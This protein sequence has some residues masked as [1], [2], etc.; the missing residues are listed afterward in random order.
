MAFFEWHD[1]ISV[2]APLIDTDHSA[3]IAIIHEL[4]Y[5]LEVGQAVDRT[6]MANHVKELVKSTQ[7]HFSREESMLRAA[8]SAPAALPKGLK[9]VRRTPTFTEAT[10]PKAPTKDH[11]TKSDIWGV[12]DVKSGR[13]RYTIPSK[14][15]TIEIEAGDTAIIEPEIPH[16][17]TPAGAVAFFVEFWRA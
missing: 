6:A 11:T 17:V 1:G 16:H 5:M 15:F 3:L 14:A 7:Y 13:V 12:I 9:P 8:M 4:N 2:G 10:V